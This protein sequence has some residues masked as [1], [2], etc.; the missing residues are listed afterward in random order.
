MLIKF[1]ETRP[2]DEIEFLDGE[3]G[4]RTGIC[5]PYDDSA[6]WRS[7]GNFYVSYIDFQVKRCNPNIEVKR[8][9]QQTGSLAKENVK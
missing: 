3:R 4:V 7:N 5:Y 2:D 1:G 8:Y 9:V 6:A